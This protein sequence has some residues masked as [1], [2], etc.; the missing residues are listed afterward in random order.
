MVTK[1]ILFLFTKDNIL[2]LSVRFIEMFMCP[3]P[4]AF[5]CFLLCVIKTFLY[6]HLVLHISD[7][8]EWVSLAQ[9]PKLSKSDHCFLRHL[10]LKI[11][12]THTVKE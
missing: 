7:Q 4:Y 8:T 10:K 9:V 11:G 1:H 2:C 12:Y 5:V 6:P 3:Q